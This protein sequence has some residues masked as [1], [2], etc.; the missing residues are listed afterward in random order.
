MRL[1]PLV[2]VWALPLTGKPVYA[3][4]CYSAPQPLGTRVVQVHGQ[5][6]LPSLDLHALAKAPAGLPVLYFF[7]GVSATTYE[8]CFDLLPHQ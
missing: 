6:R 4:P 5:V 2:A 3:P 7:Y 8:G 1:V